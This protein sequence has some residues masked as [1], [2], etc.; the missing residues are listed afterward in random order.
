MNTLGK[1]VLHTNNFGGLLGPSLAD[2]SFF[3]LLGGT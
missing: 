3:F 1:R 2:L